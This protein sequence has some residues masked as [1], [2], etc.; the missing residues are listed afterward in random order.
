MKVIHDAKNKGEIRTS[1]TDEQI[2]KMFV[3]SSDGIGIRSILVGTDGPSMKRALMELWDGI[4]L[5]L[6]A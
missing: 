4:Y 1:M 6:K 2:A 3:S 5:E